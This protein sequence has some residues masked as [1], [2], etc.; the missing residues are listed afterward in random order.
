MTE[1]GE[2][3]A[4]FLL[5]QN[6]HLEDSG[7]YLCSSSVGTKAQVSV[8]VIESRLLQI[9]KLEIDLIYKFQVRS[10]SFW[11]LVNQNQWIR[12]KSIK[13]PLKFYLWWFYWWMLYCEEVSTIFVSNMKSSIL[14]DEKW[15][16][17]L[18]L[19]RNRCTNTAVQKLD[20]KKYDDRKRRKYNV[21]LW[22]FLIYEHISKFDKVM[23]EV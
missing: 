22:F 20:D 1:K 13:Q 6:T 11:L 8:H 23:I 10:Q 7:T 14:K 21:K 18:S 5:V 17:A 9:H 15:E 19:E 3:T 12:G 16:R 2:T 4:S